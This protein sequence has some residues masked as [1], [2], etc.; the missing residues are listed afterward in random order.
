MNPNFG[1][2]KKGA[3]NKVPP[4]YRE[5]FSKFCRKLC[6]DKDYRASLK[7]RLIS[8]KVAPGVESAVWH[9]AY[10]KPPETVEVTGAGGGPV[11]HTLTLRVIKAV[12]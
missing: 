3:R 5:D 9:Y 7:R 1:G 8:G 11:A 10:G 12:T 2:R 6:E 4:A